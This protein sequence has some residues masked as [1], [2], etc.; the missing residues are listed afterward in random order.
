MNNVAKILE[1]TGEVAE[2]SGF[3]NPM[4]TIQDVPIVK[5]ALA[6]DPPDNGD[7]I[8]LIINQALYFD[9]QLDN[10]LLNPN[11]MRFHGLIVDDI[12]KH[13]SHGKSSHSIHIEEENLRIPL[14]LNGAISYFSVQTPTQEEIENLPSV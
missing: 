3:A 14:L 2:V 11:Q 4:Q 7:T 13:L 8:I 10:V 12:P 9:D 5:A 1:Y 6:Y